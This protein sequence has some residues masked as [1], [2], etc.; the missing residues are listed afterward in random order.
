MNTDE[1]KKIAE[2]EKDIK[3]MQKDHR[4]TFAEFEHK[5]S[6]SERVTDRL[7]KDIYSIITVKGPSFIS[8]TFISAPKMP[9]SV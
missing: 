3:K 8:E 4:R 7:K 1:K 5:K 9:R 2:L 6:L